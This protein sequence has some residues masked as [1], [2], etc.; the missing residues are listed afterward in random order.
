MLRIDNFK[1]FSDLNEE[2]VFKKVI[3]KYSINEKDVID[4]NIVKKSIDARNK[5]NIYY[6]YSLNIEVENDNNYP[7][8]KSIAKEEP[9]KLKANRKSPYPPIIV[10][11]GPAG[12]FCAL[13]L[14]EYGYKPIIIEQGSKVEDRIKSIENYQKEGALDEACNVQFGEGGAGTFS[15]GKLTTGVN[16]PL[17]KEVLDTFYKFGA[18]KEVTYLNKPHIGTDILRKIIVNIRHYIEDNGGIYYFDTKFIDYE[19]KEDLFII[20][21][22]NN[23][24]TTDTLV[25]AIGHSARDT[26]KLL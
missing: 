12:L 21:C 9:I 26:Y 17:I 24:F 3:S 23:T 13:K 11:S 8:I 20:K 2:E 1:I 14:I 4:Y 7:N 10:G 18:P 16:S 22:N 19:K 25:L 5:N 15:D 6:N